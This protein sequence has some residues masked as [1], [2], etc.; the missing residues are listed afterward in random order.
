MKKTAIVFGTRPEIIKLSQIIE[1]A[2]HQNIP[3][4]LISTGQQSLLNSTALQDFDIVADAHL[5]LMKTNQSLNEFISRAILELE[6][7]FIE[8]HIQAVLVHGDTGTALAAALTGYN[9][10]I[11]VFHVEAGLR[12]H[13]LNNPFPEEMNRRIISQLATLHFTPT[14]QACK[15]LLSEGVDSSKIH[16]VGNTIVDVVGRVID[17]HVEEVREREKKFLEY[18][19]KKNVLITVHRRENHKNMSILVETLKALA[20]ALPFVGFWIPV[21]PNPNVKIHLEGLKNKL[22]NLHIIE[23]LD[24]IDFLSLANLSEFIITD[25]GGVQEEATVLG[26]FCIVLRD[27]TERPELIEGGFGKLL[28]FNTDEILTEVIELVSK[29]NKVITRGSPFGDGQSSRRI[30]DLLK[31]VLR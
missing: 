21:H 11:P 27:F 28:K 20:I 15:N 1:L 10:G 6:K 22:N 17:T 16:N 23:P 12:S 4:H 24:Y 18:R 3:I 5:E 31:S 30:V 26:K 8:E 14:I 13:D 29:P 2:K 25:S 19:H 7:I 9:L